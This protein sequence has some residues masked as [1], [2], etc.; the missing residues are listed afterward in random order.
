MS[1][2]D[3]GSHV[4][5]SIVEV[6]AWAAIAWKQSIWMLSGA[7]AQYALSAKTARRECPRAAVL[8]ICDCVND[9]RSGLSASW[10]VN[11]GSGKSSLYSFIV[12]ACLNPIEMYNNK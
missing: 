10:E 2:S 8:Q 1:I 9:L 5:E 3:K 7:S 11:L 12:A 4:H 6:I